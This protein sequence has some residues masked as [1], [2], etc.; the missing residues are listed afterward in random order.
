MDDV[1]VY[2]VIGL[3]TF[4]IGFLLGYLV[5]K[6]YYSRRFLRVARQCEQSRSIVPLISE[7]EQES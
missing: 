2:I 1:M 5:L 7:L 6:E 4:I 3:L